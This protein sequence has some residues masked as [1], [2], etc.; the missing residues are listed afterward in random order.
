MPKNR[1]DVHVIGFPKPFMIPAW[2][3]GHPRLLIRS[4]AAMVLCLAATLASGVASAKAAE[5]CPGTSM[6][7][8][9]HEDD[10]LLFQSPS[11]LQDIQSERCVRTIFL[12]AGDAGRAQSY[13]GGREDGAEDAYA[14]MAGVKN[15]W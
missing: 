8:A 1:I 7:V 14:Q 9:A 6:Y 4:V 5:G 10:T 15:E 12:T 11:V 2:I 3:M 13:W